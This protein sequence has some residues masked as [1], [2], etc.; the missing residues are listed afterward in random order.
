MVDQM[1]K[2]TEVQHRFRI[3]LPFDQALEQLTACIVHEQAGFQQQF[4]V[5]RVKFEAPRGRKEF[6]ADS[7]S[8]WP[9]AGEVEQCG[10]QRGRGVW[11]FIGSPEV[12]GLSA[13]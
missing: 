2:E 11:F 13:S 10:S 12:D 9:G 6:L 5:W 8:C 3:D 1:G 7:P 4:G